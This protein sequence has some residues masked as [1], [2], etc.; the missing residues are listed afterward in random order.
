MQTQFFEYLGTWENEQNEN[1]T[2]SKYSNMH[3]YI[4]TKYGYIVASEQGCMT[5]TCVYIG[6]IYLFTSDILGL[7]SLFIQFHVDDKLYGLPIHFA[8]EFK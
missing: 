5:Y 2:P 6:L 7:R 1:E 4:G 8:T 3:T